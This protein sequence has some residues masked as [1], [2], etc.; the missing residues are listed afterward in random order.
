MNHM[1]N[2]VFR[3]WILLIACSAL[4]YGFLNRLEAQDLPSEQI[5]VIRS[6]DARLMDAEKL[7]LHPVLPGPDTT[8][9]STYMYNL[10]SRPFAVSYREAEIRPVAMRTESLPAGYNGF[11]RAGYGFPNFPLFEAGYYLS[12]NKNL[13]IGITARHHQARKKDIDNQRFR[14]THAGLYGQ[15]VINPALTLSADLSY[16]INDYYYYAI[17]FLQDTTIDENI[18]KRYTN[19]SAET[20]LF[21]SKT[22]DNGL[23]YFAGFKINHLTDNRASREHNIL[24]DFGGKKWVNDQHPFS[25][26]LILDFT[27]LRDTLVRNLNNFSLRPDFTYIGDQFTLKGG[28]NLSSSK[29]EFYFFPIL[30]M[31]YKLAGQTVVLFAGLDGDLYKN[32][33]TNLSSYNPF[34]N[35]RLDSLGNSKR[36][37]IYGGLKGLYQSFSYSAEF[38]Y[39]SIDRMA[40]YLPNTEL[41]YLFDPIFDETKVYSLEATLSKKLN[42]NIHLQTHLT[43]NF[44]NPENLEEAWHIPAFVWNFGG[45][46][47]SLDRKLQIRGNLFVESGVNYLDE[48]GDTEKL[49]GMID[50]NLG[51]DYFFTENIA[52]FTN[53][54]NLLNNKRERWVNYPSFGINAQAGVFVRF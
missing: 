49:K 4:F 3:K 32:N 50:L 11:L 17:N 48:E 34:I 28:L 30:H 24:L 39:Q 38:R 5:E 33:Y 37:K 18:L 10:T 20:R 31:D 35:H 54:Q 8:R 29:D 22:T 21:N 13:S 2:I 26:E 25:L 43:Y 9:A 41:Q 42:D 44:F 1:Q 7:R 23:D 14:D 16:D 51:A 40:F 27:N 19:F 45:L 36:T 47:T 53:V 52:A 46:F 6:F 12:E 15:F